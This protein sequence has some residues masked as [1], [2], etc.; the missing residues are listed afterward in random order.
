MALPPGCSTTGGPRRREGG[1]R[2]PGEGGVQQP[3]ARAGPVPGHAA[4]SHGHPMSSPR[5][6]APLPPSSSS[7]VSLRT[8]LE[9]VLRH[10]RAFVG[11]E[12]QAG[13]GARGQPMVGARRSGPGEWSC[14]RTASPRSASLQSKVFGF[15]RAPRAIRGAALLWLRRAT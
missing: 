9:R 6:P 14:L 3:G 10:P 5:A 8:T 7:P 11:M 12:P 2:R 13:G 4:Q 15:P 1:G